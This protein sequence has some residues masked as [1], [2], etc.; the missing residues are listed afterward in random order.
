M[1][2]TEELRVTQH[3]DGTL[4]V[5]N[6]PLPEHIEIGRELW[7]SLAAEIYDPAVMNTGPEG[8]GAWLETIGH[9]DPDREHDGYM[10][11]IDADN[12]HCT[13]RV[14]GEIPAEGPIRATLGGWAEK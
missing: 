14:A 8:N 9:A 1:P 11:H 5:D 4:H 12:V 7:D 13:Y 3:D 2:D 10:L 6:A